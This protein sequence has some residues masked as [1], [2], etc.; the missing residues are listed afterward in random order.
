MNLA[1]YSE[2]R[3]LG[4]TDPS[5]TGD[6]FTAGTVTGSAF[7]GFGSYT[8]LAARLEVATV[9][10]GSDAFDC[11]IQYKLG[12]DW[13]DLITFTQATAAVAGETIIVQRSD[14]VTWTDK[15]RVVHVTATGATAT[16]V[17]LTLAGSFGGSQDTLA[18]TGTVSLGTAATGTVTGVSD[19]ATSATVLAANTS[20]KGAIL[21]NNSTEILYVKFGATA[22]IASGG[23]TYKIPADGTLELQ[24]ERVYTGIIDGIWAN[25]STGY[26]NVTELT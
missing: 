20:R 25:N 6:T 10:G 8:H 24:G 7:T 12:E 11:K 26:V 3:L 22:S 2:K 15:M 21:H 17:I 18:V 23:Y 9:T 5:T 19:A 16:G 4:K 13:I 1:P 14:A